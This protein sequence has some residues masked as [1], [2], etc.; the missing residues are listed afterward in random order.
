MPRC[1]HR[2]VHLDIKLDH[3]LGAQ[4]AAVLKAHMCLACSHQDV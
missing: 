1:G 2:Q 3:S 4:Q